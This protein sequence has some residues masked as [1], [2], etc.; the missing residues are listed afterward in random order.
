MTIEHDAVA[1][2]S[3]EAEGDEAGQP[4]AEA[5]GLAYD[6]D[7]VKLRQNAGNYELVLAGTIDW[8]GYA[9]EYQLRASAA[10]LAK[11]AA[12]KRLTAARRHER[13]AQTVAAAAA[14]RPI[15]ESLVRTVLDEVASRDLAPV[16]TLVKLAARAFVAPGHTAEERAKWF[17]LRFEHLVEQQRESERRRAAQTALRLEQYPDYFPVAKTLPRRFVAL[18]GPTNSGKTHFAL[19]RLAAGRSGAYLAPLRLLALEGAEALAE[20][21]VLADLV[22]GEEQIRTPG[23]QHVAATV[24]M[25]DYAKPIDVAVIDEIQML[26]DAERGAA[27]TAAVCG[28]PAAHVYL[29]GAPHAERAIRAL[30]ARLGVPLEVRRFE[31]KG[32]LEMAQRSV[33]TTAHLE[34][35]DAVIAF[36]RREVLLWRDALR[37]RGL[38][39]ATIYGNLAPEVRRA[40]AARF[41]SGE[42]EVVVATDAIGMGLNLPIRRIVFTAAQKWNG[43]DEVALPPALVQQIA[44][45]AGR[46]GI[47]ERGLVAGFT[48]EVHRYIAAA[49]HERPQFASKA[50]LVSPSAQHIQLLAASTGEQSLSR[51]LHR[52]VAQMDLGDGFFVPAELQEEQERAAALDPLPLP[53]ME[54]FIFAQTPLSVRH[55][56][57]WSIW[58]TWMQHAAAGREIRLHTEEEQIRGMALQEAEDFGKVL[59]AYCWLGYRVP[60]RFTDL[61]R[62]R[63]LKA[64]CAAR[65]ERLLVQTGERA[66]ARGRRGHG[67][68]DRARVRR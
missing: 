22:T 41:R 56:G 44:G 40:E 30:A 25:T 50:F 35:G 18:L 10:P 53:L 16:E 4:S 7:G 57:Q 3:G 14:R 2:V 17:A 31:R 42:A 65:V 51:L 5:A 13:L 68:R 49:L 47:H 12:W 19:D 55:P 52:F 37:M 32:P 28:V 8:S 20:R 24:E 38:A 29:V 6:R 39:V 46:F 33:E 62:A 59:S 21:G 36:S 60:D 27:W 66:G 26:D 43:A 34:R 9:L 67:K 11:R 1:P 45:R 61:E 54:K 58:T 63:T 15:V 48:K 64:V 23:A